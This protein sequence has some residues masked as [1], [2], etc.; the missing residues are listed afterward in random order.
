M[1]KKLLVLLAAVLVLA[2]VAVGY[3]AYARTGSG[4]ATENAVPVAEGEV[5]LAQ[6]NLLFR[7]TAEGPG[8]GKVGAVPVGATTGPRQLSGLSCDRFAFSKRTGLCLAVQ[9]GT[10]PPETDVLIVDEHL[11]VH[12]KET[13]PGTPS[14]ARVSPDGRFAYWTLFVSGDS[15]AETGFS[16]RAGVYDTQ[17]DKLIKSIEQLAVFRD[18]ERYY[19]NDVNYWGITFAP[20]GN[21][22]YATL[23]SKGHTYL[24]EGDFAKFRAKVLRDGVECPSLSPDGTRV[25]F[26]KRFGDGWRI[27]VLELSTM[28]ETVLAETRLVDDQPLWREESVLYGLGGDI[29]SV[30]ADGSGAPLL[31]VPHGVSP[32]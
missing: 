19:A 15:Y 16:T 24:I 13:L 25:A 21:R 20:D 17:E 26:K 12:H 29:W 5:M 9:P 18:G 30:K 27:A 31:L 22:F 6:E 14:R 23:G 28:R 4:G 7:N 3:V 2:G 10:L 11:R 8:F 32:G 1:K